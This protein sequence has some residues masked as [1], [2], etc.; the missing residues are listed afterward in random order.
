MLHRVESSAAHW[1]VGAVHVQLS[2]VN[3]LQ[4]QILGQTRIFFFRPSE[5]RVM[6]TVVFLMKMTGK[7]TM[8][9][10]ISGVPSLFETSYVVNA[11]LDF[12]DKDM[13]FH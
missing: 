3:A 2:Q 10:L 13:C 8:M 4:C 12:H 11:I 5:L 6:T 9:V 7:A 1:Y